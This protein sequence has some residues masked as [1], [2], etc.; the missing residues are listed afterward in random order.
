MELQYQLSNGNW[1]NCNDRTEEF[2]ARC[3]EQAQIDRSAVLSLLNE[4]RELR[5]SPSDW[6]SVCRDL[7][8]IERIREARRAAAPPVQMVKCSCGH[9]VPRM[10]VM[11]ASIGSSCP[12]C[13]DRMSN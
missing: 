3:E 1:A 7:E 4:G 12:E 5:N 9:T 10:S 2:L 11:S 8:A 6:Y 13:Y